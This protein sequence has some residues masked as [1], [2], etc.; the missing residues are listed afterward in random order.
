MT[1]A[2]INPRYK[3]LKI[4]SVFCNGVKFQDN[5]GNTYNSSKIQAQIVNDKGEIEIVT[6]AY[7]FSQYGYGS[8]WLNRCKALLSNEFNFNTH[9]DNTFENVISGKKSDFHKLKDYKDSIDEGY[10]QLV[11]YWFVKF[12]F[13]NN[14][15]NTVIPL[16]KI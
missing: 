15:I 4:L 11:R 5:N 7:L 2:I 8:E 10:Y 9:Y 14:C 3:G 6:L 13:R 1:S 16:N 12:Y